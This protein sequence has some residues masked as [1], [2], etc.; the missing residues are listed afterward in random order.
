MQEKNAKT[1]DGQARRSAATRRKLIDAARTAFA[2]TGF[3][4]ASTPAI[5]KAAGVS[6]GALYHQ[7]DDKNALF[8]AVVE[9]MQREVYDAI[10]AATLDNDDPLAALKLG[11]RVFLQMAARPDFVRIVMID[12]PAVMGLREWRRLDREN[13]IASLKTGLE[14]AMA[15]GTIRPLP[16]EELAVLLSGAMNEGVL[17]LLE[18][19]DR[20]T[21]LQ[22]LQTSIDA[23]FDGLR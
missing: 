15:A 18:A 23:M 13:G 17:H 22:D 16:V 8:M 6:R 2:D 21:A 10:E 3:H 20:V 12:G 1:L 11:S 14:A 19:E 7:Y 9:D 5:A 4:E